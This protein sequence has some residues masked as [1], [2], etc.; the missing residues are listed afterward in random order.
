M[1]NWVWCGEEIGD[2]A[3]EKVHLLSDVRNLL[4]AP[5]RVWPTRSPVTHTKKR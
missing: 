3:E 4:P 5:N 2:F 1:E